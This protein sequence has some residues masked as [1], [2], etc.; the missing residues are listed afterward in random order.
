MMIAQAQ[1]QMQSHH[2]LRQEQSKQETLRTWI[3][4]ERPK[5]EAASPAVAG[6]QVGQGGDRLSLS[7]T[8]MRQYLQ[9]SMQQKAPVEMAVSPT[10]GEDPK[11]T[12]IRM[13][14]EILTGKRIN[15]VTPKN[16]S[17][18][19]DPAVSTRPAEVPSQG[20]PPK[21]GWGLEYDYHEVTAEHEEMTF[22]AKGG[23]E[24]ADG[25]HLN[26][27]MELAMSREFVQ[28]KDIRVRAGDAVL[29]DPLVINFADQP[30]SLT[31]QKVAF[32]LNMDG[33]SEQISSVAPGSG[34]L[35]LDR[36]ND[37]QATDGSELFGP[38]SGSGFMELAALDSDANGWLDDNDPMF[39]KLQVWIKGYVQP[40]FNSGQSLN[41]VTETAADS[42]TSLKGLGIGAILLSHQ[43]TAFSLND[44]QNQQLGQ[45]TGSGI[46]LREDGN[47]GSIQEIMLAV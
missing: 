18:G 11:L 38:A 36:N 26:V 14:L 7:E 1:I 24:T 31:D 44:R 47:A 35:F 25:Q 40:S 12:A 10:S 20:T 37:G 45:V 34:L 8:A 19:V 29:V 9:K 21:A 27:A 17:K 15:T 33:V 5:F 22:K 3:G 43:A 32:D 46:F 2:L 13:I 30:P 41:G 28:T 23:V 4:N 42:V 16:F 6:D 39:A